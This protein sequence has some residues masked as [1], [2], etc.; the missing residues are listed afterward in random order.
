MSS[1]GTEPPRFDWDSS[2][3][4]YRFGWK[5]GRPF[6]GEVPTIPAIFVRWSCELVSPVE[7]SNTVTLDR[8]L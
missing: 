4:I 5:K 8:W 1:S 6:R 2:R 7:S 3:A